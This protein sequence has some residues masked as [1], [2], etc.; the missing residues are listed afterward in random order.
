MSCTL[1]ERHPAK[2]VA[3]TSSSP[4]TGTSGSGEAANRPR[5]IDYPFTVIQMHMNPD[6]Q[7]EGRLSLATK[8]IA[9]KKRQTIILENYGIQP[10]LLTNVRRQPPSR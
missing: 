9:D 1:R 2:T 7:G 5:T 8:I 4:R 10:V 6:G 3:R